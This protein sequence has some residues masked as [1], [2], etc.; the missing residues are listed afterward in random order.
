MNTPTND[1]L[2]QA[3]QAIEVENIALAEALAQEVIELEPNDG[4]AWAVM[5]HVAGLI[6]VEDK[7]I[8]WGVKA[9]P[10]ILSGFDRPTNSHLQVMLDG[11]GQPSEANKY[12]LIRSLGYGFWTEIF[13]VLGGLLLAEITGRLPCVLWGANSLFCGEEKGNAFPDFFN[14]IG[15][16]FLSEI[17]AVSGDEIFPHKWAIS[18]IEA[19]QA[20]KDN[21]PHQGGEGQM[22]AVW[23]LN[24]PERVVVSDYR[25]GVVDLLPWIPADHTLN[26]LSLDTI[27]NRLFTKFL[28][29]NLAIKEGVMEQSS[30]LAGRKTVSVHLQ[31]SDTLSGLT[32][33]E[34]VNSH[35][36]AVIE[37]ATAKNYAVW[38][39][40]D[41]EPY[42][43]DYQ[44][45]FG[46]SL[47]YQDV[48]RTR[49][50]GSVTVSLDKPDPQRFG[51]Q[52]A[53]DVLVAAS[54]DRFIGNGSYNPSC[55][56]DFQMEGDETKKHLFLPNINRR[57]FLNL[58]RD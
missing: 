3:I 12:I 58:Y 21:P 42:I 37:Q 43:D 39:M 11:C 20:D 27:I 49:D 13:H 19:V 56:V 40:T 57:R 46:S 38:L 48:F 55:I 51:E 33:L 8:T 45:R 18:G 50:L 24:R 26:G 32:K 17:R 1:L 31:G 34:T 5:A 53:I 35:Y 2:H 10:E 22:A 25:I 52:Q 4:V 29:P 44:A 23:L 41:Y 9:D 30:R 28:K 54:C 7:A 16:E 36:P 6:G 14:D 47:V 15:S